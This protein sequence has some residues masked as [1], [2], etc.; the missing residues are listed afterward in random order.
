[1]PISRTVYD[2]QD[3]VTITMWD[4]DA[5]EACA[6]DPKRYTLG[7][8]AGWGGKAA[9]TSPRASDAPDAPAADEA[10]AAAAT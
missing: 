2:K 8:P 10:P 3:L 6:R 7:K 9:K 4:V 1:M 5:R